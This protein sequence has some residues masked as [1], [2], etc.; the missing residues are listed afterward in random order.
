MPLPVSDPTISSTAVTAT[1]II[2]SLFPRIQ[3]RRIPLPQGSHELAYFE[4][5]AAEQLD[6]SVDMTPLMDADEVILA[7]YAWSSV[8][9]ELVVTSV[10]IALKGVLVFVWGGLENTEYQLNITVTTIFGR[11]MQFK[12]TIAVSDSASEAIATY[13]PPVLGTGG[14]PA[15]SYLVDVLGV[16]VAPGYIDV[17]GEVLFPVPA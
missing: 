6:Y 8:A 2:D 10:R 13:R 17:L 11:V 7:A 4:K 5:R 14:D 9:T 1:A 15:Q 16:F 3:E 12:A